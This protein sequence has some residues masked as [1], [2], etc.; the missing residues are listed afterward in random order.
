MLTVDYLRSRLA[1][2]GETGVITWKPKDGHQKWNERFAGRPAL[3]KSSQRGGYLVGAVDAVHLRAHRVAYA[4][5]NGSWPSGEV[6][7]I[8]GDVTD[9]RIANLRDVTPSEN[10]RNQ[11]RPRNNRSG[12][13]GVWFDARR[14]KWRAEARHAGVNY[15]LGSFATKEE[16][17][18][19]RRA[20]DDRF[21]YHPNHGRP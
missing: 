9:N 11:K 20:A 12:L 14:N 8:N 15:K 2:D 7:H 3:N 18:L 13:I 16:A 19:A 4:L 10:C 6:D 5:A 21:G 1:Y 17:E